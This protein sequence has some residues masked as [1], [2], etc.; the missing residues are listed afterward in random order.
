MPF[1]SPARAD[2]ARFDEEDSSPRTTDRRF[3][4]A[5]IS[6]ADCQSHLSLVL[7]ASYSYASFIVF[8]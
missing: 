8:R 2:I 6:G 1:R 4:L 3:V 7:W 5:R